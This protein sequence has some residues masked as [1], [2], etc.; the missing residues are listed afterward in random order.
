MF[1]IDQHA[2][3]ERIMLE[4]IKSQRENRQVEVQGLLEPVT[5]EVEPRLAPTMDSH[6]G[7]LADFRLHDRGFWR[8]DLPGQDSTGGVAGPRLAG[9]LKGV[10][11]YFRRAIG[12]KIWSIP[13]LAIAPFERDR[14]SAILKC[15]GIDKA[16]GKAALPNSCPHGRPTMVQLTVARIEKNSAEASQPLAAPGLEGNYES[17][18]NS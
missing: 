7:E 3:H 5:F 15:Q 9:S 16:P 18:P 2:A 17:S 1:L 10:A 13:W 8:A 12:P 6:L 14:S 4:K 11:G